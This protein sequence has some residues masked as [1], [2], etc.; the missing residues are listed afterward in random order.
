MLKI[1]HFRCEGIENYC[2]TDQ[3]NPTFSFMLESDVP[4]TVL[5]TAKLSIN[6]WEIVTDNQISIEYQG[7]TLEPYTCYKAELEVTD[8]HGQVAYQILEFETGKL[9][10][11]WQAKWITD[12]DY[13]F[14]EK[15]VSPKPMT[16]R[17]V[18]SI[19]EKV[20][21]ARIYSTA[22]GIYTLFINGKRVGDDYFA[23]GFTSYKSNLQYQVYD[24]TDDLDA[25]NTLS[26]TVAGGW[27]VG[28]FIYSRK[29]RVTAKRQSLL[30][31]LHVTYEDGRTEVISTDTTWQVSMEGPYEMADFYDGETYN[32][33]LS[34]EILSYHGASLECVKIN[35][36]ISATYGSLVRA[37][38]EMKPV[39]VFH[40]NQELIFDF[41]QNFA[42]LVEFTINAK[43]GQ[44]VIIRHAEILNSDGSLNTQFLRTAK[45]TLTYTCCEGIQSY[46]PEFTYMG[47]RYISVT[48]IDEEQII[49]ISARALYSN[50]EQV[51]EFHSSHAGLNQLH[52]NIIW[53]SKSNFVDIP[54]DCPQ[55]DERMG[56]TGDIAVFAP[57]ATFLFDLTRFLDKWLIDV[58]NEQLSTGG[59]PNTVPSQGF[60]FPTTM[61]TMAVDFW[62]DAALLVPWAQY[63]ARGDRRVLEKF[64]PMMKKYVDACKF[65]ANLGSFGK[66]RYIWNTHHMLHF[67]DWVAPDVPKMSQWQKRS[68]YT[69][70]AS[71][72][73]TSYLLAEVAH[74]LGKDDEAQKY[75]ELSQKVSD[76]YETLL[77][78][79]GRLDEEFQTG[80]VLPLQYNMLSEEDKNIALTRLVTLIKKNDYKIGTGFPGTPYIL[81]VLAN[82]GYADVAMDMLLNESCPSWL[83]EVTMGATTIWERWDGLD[84]NGQCPISDDG[85]DQMISYN[86][87]ASGAVGD[88]LYRKVAGIEPL[89]PGYRSFKIDPIVNDAISSA[90]ASY[91][92]PF[93]KIKVD[94][95][96]MDG[97]IAM[98]IDVPVGTTAFVE[99]ENQHIVTL[100]SGSHYIERKLVDEKI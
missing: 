7:P 4:D 65:W 9:H 50:I 5:K 83:Y 19:K 13:S 17:K 74:I 76:A 20:K 41:G 29:N 75:H 93:G 80:Y 79:N 32:A 26:A 53:S 15:K 55:R 81:F 56:W 95:K 52:S 59:I 18:F 35:P 40:H 37:H 64:Y 38:E 73:N 61:P 63:Q 3:K 89:E 23:P 1:V 22:L 24:I 98:E 72:K 2:I 21:S 12:G 46:R 42:G 92:S 47:F 69:A 49:S 14:T 70:T 54:T 91:L 77:M 33:L 68:K 11:G 51:G 36:R 84:E 28:S 58:S 34:S 82:N 67:G 45:A 57:T 43:A 85:T 94:W 71:L 62:G 25:D 44:T 66:H 90:Y 31:E 97:F 88:F 16:F 6:G 10:D 87:Y 100:R 27:A 48:G 60:G 8:N 86:H 30:L 99:L 96:K 78:N 39:A